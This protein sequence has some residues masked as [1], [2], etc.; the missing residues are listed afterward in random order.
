MQQMSKVLQIK[1]FLPLIF[2][3]LS[4]FLSFPFSPSLKFMLPTLLRSPTYILLSLPFASFQIGRYG[5][6]GGTFIAALYGM[7]LENFIEETSWGFGAVSGWCAVI[8]VIV[9]M[10]GFRRLRR[11]QK[12]SMW[13]LDRTDKGR[14]LST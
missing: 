3:Q 12:L 1:A 4:P 5:L 10:W 6:S 9:C 14:D 11:V 2:L 7:N 13:G 8:S